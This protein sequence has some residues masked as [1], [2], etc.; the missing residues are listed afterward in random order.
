MGLI[1][2]CGTTE[3]SARGCTTIN[4]SVFPFSFA[5]TTGKTIFGLRAA[6][7]GQLRGKVTS[8]GGTTASHCVLES[9][10]ESSSSSDAMSD[11]LSITASSSISPSASE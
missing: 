5:V 11:D 2:C 6:T 1:D 7:G 3:G 4:L 8:V 10:D 9:T